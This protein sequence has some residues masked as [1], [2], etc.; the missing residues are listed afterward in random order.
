MFY[1]RT[2][3]ELLKEIERFQKCTKFE[4][5]N[6]NIH[7]LVER[8]KMKY[9]FA[10]RLFQKVVT[11]FRSEKELVIFFQLIL[12]KIRVILIGLPSQHP[13]TAKKKTKKEKRN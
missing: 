11:N 9:I 10:D 7:E 5:K 6:Q 13:S 1:P 12:L 3:E 4:E 8:K 2:F